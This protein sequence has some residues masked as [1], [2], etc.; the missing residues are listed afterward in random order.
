MVVNVVIHPQRSVTFHNMHEIV[1]PSG[2]CAGV[3]IGEKGAGGNALIRSF[4]CEDIA[5]IAN[6]KNELNHNQTPELWQ[7]QNFIYYI[8]TYSLP[9]AVLYKPSVFPSTISYI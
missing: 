7:T 9:K 4:T 8:R 3:V 2:Y 5:I 1:V 6:A